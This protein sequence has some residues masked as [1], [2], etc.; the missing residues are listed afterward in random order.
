MRPVF[1][2]SAVHR[3]KFTGAVDADGHLLEDAGLWDAYIERKY[4]DRAMRLKRDENGLEKCVGCSLC[5]AACPAGASEGCAQLGE[6]A[7]SSW[8]GHQVGDYVRR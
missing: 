1:D 2:P 8:L 4:K 3:L 5:A 6:Q 7:A